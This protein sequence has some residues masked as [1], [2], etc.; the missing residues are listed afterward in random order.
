MKIAFSECPPDES[1]YTFPYHVWGYLEEGE[2]VSSAYRQGFLPAEYDFSRFYL[3][4]SIRVKLDEFSSSSR[5]RYVERKCG[6]ISD[7][8]LTRDQFEFSAEWHEMV[9]VYFSVQKISASYRHTRFLQQIDSPLATHVSCFV[10]E[11]NGKP[12]GLVPI[13]IRD[14]I[15]QYGIPVYDPSYRTVSI[16]NYIMAAT[17]HRLRARGV[18]HCYLGYCS[19]RGSL[20][21]TRFPGM[22]FFNGRG[23]SAD[24]AELHFAISQQDL[25]GAPH[26]LSSPEYVKDFGEVDPSS[27]NSKIYSI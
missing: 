8:L 18:D 4:R 22:Q 26:L 5:M 20:Y 27:L 9:E 12:V 7:A 15:S 2:S 16:G 14:G 21:K 17:L 23:W 10:D 24:R 25:T 3:A 11:S 6:S 1:N 19:D 13:L